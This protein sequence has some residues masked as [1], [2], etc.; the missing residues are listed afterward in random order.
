MT[1]HESIHEQNDDPFMKLCEKAI[2]FVTMA[3]DPSRVRVYFG[4]DDHDAARRAAPID[5]EPEED[6]FYDHFHQRNDS[7]PYID[8]TKTEENFDVLDTLSLM[9]GEGRIAHIHSEQGLE[10]AW[11]DIEHFFH[12]RQAIAGANGQET[13][14]LSPPEDHAVT[15]KDGI[16]TNYLSAK[17]IMEAHVLAAESVKTARRN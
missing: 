2:L 11:P 8:Y 5:K 9:W 7:F 15:E 4:A 17:D 1:T 12:V 16:P 3:E 6:E 13:E 14:L 10:K